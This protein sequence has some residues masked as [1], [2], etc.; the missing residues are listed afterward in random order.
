VL[1]TAKRIDNAKLCYRRAQ[2]YLCTPFEGACTDNQVRASGESAGES[3]LPQTLRIVFGDDRVNP[4]GD[5]I[6]RI[7]LKNRAGQ[8]G[9]NFEAVYSSSRNTRDF[10]RGISAEKGILASSWVQSRDGE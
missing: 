1:R 7:P 8:S 4:C 5:M 2:R 3:F 6:V 9:L 10:S